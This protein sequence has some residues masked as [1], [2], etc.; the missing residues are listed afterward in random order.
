M[1]KIVSFKI[2]TLKKKLILSFLIISFIPSI[3][4]NY[5]YF[6]DE[7]ILLEDYTKQNTLNDLNYLVNNTEKRL[8]AAE[9]LSDW[10]TINGSVKEAINN[11]N[12]ERD[13]SKEILNLINLQ[14]NIEDMILSSSLNGYISSVIVKGNNGIDIRA[15]ADAN[16]IDIDNIYNTKW[17]IPQ[18][19][20]RGYVDWLGIYNNPASIYRSKYIL[21]VLR[22]ILSSTNNETIGF[23]YIGFKIEVISEIFEDYEIKDGVIFVIDNNKNIVYHSKEEYIGKSIDNNLIENIN[24]INGEFILKEDNNKDTYYYSKSEYLGWIICQRVSKSYLLPQKRNLILIGILIFLLSLLISLIIAVFLS[25][26]LT[27]PLKNIKEKMKA[28]SVGDFSRNKKIEGQDELGLLGKGI[29]NMAQNIQKLLDDLID[30][31][32]KKR[33]IKFKFLQ[34]QINPH[35]IY[36]TLNSIKWLAIIQKSEIISESV[37]AL[38]R[39]IRGAFS[40]KQEIKIKEEIEL[41][42]D[43]IKLMKIRYVDK[44]DVKYEFDEKVLNRKILNMTLQPIVENAVFHG[45]EPK[46]CT[47]VIKIIIEENLNHIMIKIEDDGI[48][49]EKERIKKIF[50]EKEYDIENSYKNNHIGIKNIDER[51]KLYY[52]SNFGLSIESIEGEY[53]KVFIKIPI[54]D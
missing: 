47:G 51:I 42:K 49:I 14:E 13:S 33:E 37:T 1:K 54:I 24:S 26:N 23:S 40:K 52:G 10:T 18:F 12:F 7:K 36:N 28:I 3:F 39:F 22:P 31:E 21:P 32:N 11:E 34:S 53:T 29:N 2:V 16:M 43:Y 17:Y 19:E 45:I 4:I 46:D 41:L 44:F 15:G 8:K 20:N 50:S 27:K 35:F 38:G 25:N 6:Y 30:E 9:Q 48:G 5:Y